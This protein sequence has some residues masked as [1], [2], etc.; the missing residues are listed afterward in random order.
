LSKKKRQNRPKDIRKGKIIKV[1]L[2]LIALLRFLN[3]DVS[4]FRGR[5]KC[6][7]Q[8]RIFD[9]ARNN[10]NGTYLICFNGH[11]SLPVKLRGF[12]N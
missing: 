4:R 1:F 3:K 5:L 11:H 9:E 8:E 2:T 10:Q 6:H 12:L 7:P